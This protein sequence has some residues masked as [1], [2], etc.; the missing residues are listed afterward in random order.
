MDNDEEQQQTTRDRDHKLFSSP[1][2]FIVVV[3]VVYK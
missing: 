3:L 2:I 1:T